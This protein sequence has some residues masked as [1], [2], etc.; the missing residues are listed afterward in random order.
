MWSIATPAKEQHRLVSFSIGRSTLRTNYHVV[1][2]IHRKPDRYEL[3][4]VASNGTEGPLRL[5]AVDAVHDLALVEADAPLV[6]RCRS[7]NHHQRCSPLRNGQSARS[8]ADH[9][10]RHQRRR[11]EPDG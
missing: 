11:P 6:T 3:R 4:F 7:A 10:R 1:K 9:R 2:S 8:R 5:V